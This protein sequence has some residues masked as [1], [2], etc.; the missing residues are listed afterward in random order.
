MTVLDTINTL[1]YE[2]GSELCPVELFSV[3]YALIMLIKDHEC[4]EVWIYFLLKYLC[5]GCVNY[6]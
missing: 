3:T 5:P 1:I 6:H 2:P 4:L